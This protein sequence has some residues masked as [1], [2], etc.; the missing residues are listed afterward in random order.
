MTTKKVKSTGR[1]GSRYGVG[2][3]KR[4]LKLEN[5]QK[6]LS[7]C[8]FCGFKKVKRKAAGLFTCNKCG[9]KFTGGAYVTETLAGKSIKK[10]VN[11]KSFNVEET[12]L[13]EKKSKTSYSEIEEEVA[14]SVK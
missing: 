5:R 10:I 13:E 6:N 8:P 12:T 7:A 11:Q 3:R 14:G 9:A 1:F 4:L 2:I